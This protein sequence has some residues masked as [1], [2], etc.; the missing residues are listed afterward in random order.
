MN[1][2]NIKRTV[3]VTNHK[4]L[5]GHGLPAAAQHAKLLLRGRDLSQPF[6]IIHNERLQHLADAVR[7]SDYLFSKKLCV[8]V[9]SIW[10]VTL[11]VDIKSPKLHQTLSK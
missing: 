8:I 2:S 3:V 10:V 6:L 11:M 1:G 7:L 4:L 5:P 9:K